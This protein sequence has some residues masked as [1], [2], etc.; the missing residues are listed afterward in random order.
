MLKVKVNFVNHSKFSQ[1]CISKTSILKYL[2]SLCRN[3]LLTMFD[4]N[5]IV[6]DLLD[7]NITLKN[8]DYDDLIIHQYNLNL[9]D[10]SAIQGKIK[11]YKWESS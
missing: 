8:K 3:E 4:W 5:R 11:Y 10:H 1:F 2:F 9:L 6:N 7:H